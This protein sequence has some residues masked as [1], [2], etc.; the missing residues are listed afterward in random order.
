MRLRWQYFVSALAFALTLPGGAIFVAQQP[1]ATLSRP[2]TTGRAVI[3]GL[4]VSD[5]PTPSPVRRAVVTAV[6]TGQDV[7]RTTVTDDDGR[8][9][10]ASLAP[11]R[12]TLSATKAAHLVAAYGAKRP[13]RPGTSLSLNDAQELRNVRLTMAR[14]GVLAGAVRDANG[15]PIPGLAVL[16][17]NVTEPAS[18]RADGGTGIPSTDDRGQ[19]RFF[20]LPPGDYVVLATGQRTPGQRSEPTARRT[21]AEMNALLAMIG[22]PTGRNAQPKEQPPTSQPVVLAPTY[23]PGTPL[24]AAAQRI[25]VGPGDVRE[26]LDFVSAPVAVTTIEGLVTGGGFTQLAIE[27]D[28]PPLPGL[29][30]FNFSPTLSKPPDANGRFMFT[31]VPPG[32]YVIRARNNPDGQPPPVASTSGRG[33]GAGAPLPAA[34]A[35]SFGPLAQPPTKGDLAYAAVEIAVMG[36][37]LNGVTLSLGPGAALAGGITLVGDATVD[38]TKVRITVQ[39]TGSTGYSVS[40]PT[41]VGNPF[42]T[43]AGVLLAPDGSFS[44]RGIAPGRYTL[45]FTLAPD[46]AKMWTVR[47]AVSEQRDLLDGPFE[48]TPGMDVKDIR[49]IVSTKTTEVSGRVETPAGISPMDYYIVAFPSDRAQWVAGSRRV[50]SV[51]PGNDG[52]YA[53]RDLPPGQYRMAAVTNVEPRDLNNPAFLDSLLPASFSIVLRD[54]EPTIQHLRVVAK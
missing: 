35:P 51:Q 21:V 25:T 3:A 31:G 37:P 38:L 52:T 4:V 46:M 29:L 54:G 53:L 47:S 28:A 17:L 8:F 1:R 30:S 32:R 36:Q 34:T 5:G 49:V 27:G 23:F 50:R 14:G 20:G 7:S 13:G 48:L 19:F 16:A 44:L 2:P 9:E 24:F 45:R 11:G 12:Y 39:T 18:T 6:M 42:A 40:G 22:Q 41:A 33:G 10:L 43:T 26:G 15:R